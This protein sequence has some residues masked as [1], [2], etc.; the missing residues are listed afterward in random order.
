MRVVHVCVIELNLTIVPTGIFN[1][2]D[3]GSHFVITRAVSMTDFI[4]IVLVTLLALGQIAIATAQ[5]SY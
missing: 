4:H 3:H 2:Y 1:E 5:C